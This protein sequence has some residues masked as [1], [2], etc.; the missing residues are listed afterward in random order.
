MGTISDT[1]VAP[2]ATTSASWLAYE[3]LTSS[4]NMPSATPRCVAPDD[5]LRRIGRPRDDESG[6]GRSVG[7]G[8]VGAGGLAGGGAGGGGGAVG[9][10]G[11]E[12]GCARL[13]S[14]GAEALGATAWAAA[15]RAALTT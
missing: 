4:A 15:A 10:L 2:S 3:K 9:K 7:G 14:A 5:G 13:S 12:R 8:V 11:V 6:G 1:W